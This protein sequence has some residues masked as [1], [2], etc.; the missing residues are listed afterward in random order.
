MQDSNHFPEYERMLGL[1]MECKAM[2]LAIAD[3]EDEHRPR[4]PIYSS[5]FWDERKPLA[6]YAS[7]R[8]ERWELLRASMDASVTD[9]QLYVNN[10]E[11]D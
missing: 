9:G 2:R 5:K 6:F 1:V 7:S 10:E 11:G 8:I 4:L 3:P